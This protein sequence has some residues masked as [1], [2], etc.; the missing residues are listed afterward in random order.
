MSVESCT[1][2]FFLERVGQWR[3][4]FDLF[5]TLQHALAETYTRPYKRISPFS[6]FVCLK[7]EQTLTVTG[8][9]L[10]FIS[11]VVYNGTDKIGWKFEV[12]W[13]SPPSLN[14]QAVSQW[15]VFNYYSNVY[16]YLCFS[17][18]SFRKRTNVCLLLL[19]N[20]LGYDGIIGNGA[21]YCTS[22]A[23][24]AVRNPDWAMG[25]VWNI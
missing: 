12:T 2:L 5:L 11:S 17:T 18:A 25:G 22:T 1:Y 21:P 20:V 8:L 15:L 7:G 19:Y 14:C 13:T 16:S 6:Y 24:D 23:R 9:C 3:S 4:H 10:D